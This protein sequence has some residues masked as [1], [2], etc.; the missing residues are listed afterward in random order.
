MSETTKRTYEIILKS[1]ITE[2]NTKGANIT[3]EGLSEEEQLQLLQ[4]LISECNKHM[5]PFVVHVLGYE[6]YWFLDVWFHNITEYDMN[7]SVAAR[8]LGKSFFFSRML[9]DYLTF[10]FD[11]YRSIVS[12]YNEAATY[13]FIKGSRQDFEN[14][15]LLNTKISDQKSA[16]WNKGTL[17]F[18]NGSVIKGISITSQIRRLHVHYFIAD[19]IINDEQKLTPE[20]IKAKIYATILPTL[21]RKRGKFILVGTR[22]T[23][24]DIYA[25]FL[26]KAK[27]QPNYKYCEMGIKLDEKQ[28]KVYIV[29]SDENGVVKKVEDKDNL[30]DYKD[31]LSLKVAEPN[32]FAR[33]Y[34]CE[35]VSAQDVPFPLDVLLECRD[36][37]LSYQLVG[38]PGTV[39]CGGLDSSN[40]TVKDADDTVLII[41][42]LDS[43]TNIV[44]D[45]AYGN[46]TL[47][48]PERLQEL[49]KRMDLFEKPTV[50]AEQ[51]SMGR[52]NIDMINKDGYRLMNFNTDRVKKN[53]ITDYSSFLVKRRKIR[54]P[55]KLPR[56]QKLTDKIIH[57]LAGVRQIKTRGGLPTYTGTT[58]HDDYYIA[59][60]LMSKQLSGKGRPITI[61]SFNRKELRN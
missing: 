20:A 8:G 53:D 37:E 44:L 25:Y 59:F 47:E 54:F 6:W 33:E 11:G 31:L 4:V 49:K 34:E 50:L 13:D 42:H 19:D 7:C 35:I 56:D 10:I 52:T 29:H 27:D 61:R 1:F 51:N 58:K 12:S 48:A 16:D 60:V 57:Q 18:S 36:R 46:N 41:G 23:E 22:F 24:D 28:E 17:D 45:L 32:Y 38:D 2:L 15:E 40:S 39:Y 5:R 43:D 30:Y 26:E 3:Y 9:P 21:Q 14:N 55:Y